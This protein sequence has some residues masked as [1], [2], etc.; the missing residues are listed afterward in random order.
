MWDRSVAGHNANVTRAK[1]LQALEINHAYHGA[2]AVNP[3]LAFESIDHGE[4]GGT[5]RERCWNAWG[6]AIAC[7]TNPISSPAASS[8]GWR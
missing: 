1:F 8:S 7:I 4:S 6:S 5:A 2:A 3:Y